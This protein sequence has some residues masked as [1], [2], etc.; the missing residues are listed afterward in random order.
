MD[1]SIV[2]ENKKILQ[3][4]SAAFT[5]PGRKRD[6]N[7][8]VIFHQ[9]SQT[10]QGEVMGLFLVC[11]GMG[12]HRAGEIASRIAVDT[13]TADLAELFLSSRKFSPQERTHPSSLTLSQKIEAAIHKANQEIQRFSQN[14]PDEAPDLGTT[15]TL[16]L[17]H[18]EAAHIANVGD[19]RAYI[20]RNG[21][22]MQI[23]R[24][25]SLA[26]QLASKGLIDESEIASHPRSNIILRALGVGDELEV[27][28]FD[29]VLQPG[30][31]LLLCSDGLWKSMG[32]PVELAH[33]LGLQTT[34]ADLCQQLVAQAKARDGSDNISAIVVDIKQMEC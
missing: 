28:V 10:E 2:F 27:D 15:V 24:D 20:W 7:Q 25:H 1:T 6:L 29:W 12:G 5:D 21:K 14:H 17:I 30:D 9:T 8:D 16:A 4:D 23:T 22:T 3:L 11:D 34:A 13:I 26:A 19:G 32:N 33:W 18:G 31:K